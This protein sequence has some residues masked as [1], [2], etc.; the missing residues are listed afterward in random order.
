MLRSAR[1]LL[2]SSR[3][4]IAAPS[5][6]CRGISTSL[7]RTSTPSIRPTAFTTPKIQTKVSVRHAST[8]TPRRTKHKK[9][10]KGRI[11]VRIGGSTKGTTIVFGE[12]GIRLMSEGER[13]TAKQLQTAEAII[14]RKIKVVKGARIFQ[15]L[16]T[17][18]PVCTKGNETRMGK[19][20]GS[21]DYWACRVPSG[22]ILF[23]V[24][25]GGIQEQV[26][27]A[28]LMEAAHKLPG[29]VVFA[30]RGEPPYAGRK[31]VQV[32]KAEDIVGASDPVPEGE[33]ATAPVVGP[34]AA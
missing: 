23:E 2:A 17:D 9:A 27:F 28:A 8:Y 32:A 34:I 18:L 4:A 13:M 22:K 25:G 26:A 15:R 6:T 12:Y 16:H 10:H 1:S 20:K 30:R 3:A 7:L 31:P 29:K 11:P 24:G 19:G 21:F 14:K 33:F 5:M